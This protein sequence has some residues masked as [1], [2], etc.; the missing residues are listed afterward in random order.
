MSL[1]PSL[2]ETPHLADVFKAFPSQV[3]SLLAYHDE[4]L[5][6]E[7]PLTVAEREL[8]ATY[9]SGLNACSFCFG[10]H[11][12]YA[13]VFGITDEVIDAL[14]V[15]IT[16]APVAD[17]LKPLLHY[18]RKLTNL[19]AQLV[20]A[21]AELV[22][23]AGWDERALY[24]AIQVCALFN[25]MNRIIEGTGVSFDYAANPPSDEE[26]ALR[27]TRTYSDFGREIGLDD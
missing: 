1:F 8:I 5:R 2:P 21:D 3:K 6:G 10:A 15:D 19:P 13:N 14:M 27:K 23:A 9:V 11:R 18:V 20:D 4:L 17:K 12:L 26:M 25:F 16:T 22:Y 7:S 24:D